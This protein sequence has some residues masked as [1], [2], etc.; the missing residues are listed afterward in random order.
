MHLT[1]SSQCR[2]P[3]ISPDVGS[4][5]ENISL[6]FPLLP[7]LYCTV[8]KEAR[9]S[10]PTLR[11]HTPLYF[12]PPVP[13]EPSRGTAESNRS[14]ESVL[15]NMICAE[16][17]AQLPL[18]PLSLSQLTSPPAGLTTVR[19]PES[20]TTGCPNHC[21]LGLRSRV[22]SSPGRRGTPCEYWRGRR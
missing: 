4:G 17:S 13:R 22:L 2:P 5:L 6:A 11:Q 16:C 12:S 18:P 15:C 14:R 8:E 3:I 20:C 7:C 19:A 10:S 1:R 9:R 21:R